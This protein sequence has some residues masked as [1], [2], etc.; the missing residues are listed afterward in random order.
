MASSIRDMISRRDASP[1]YI[2]PRGH[3]D[4]I[5]GSPGSAPCRRCRRLASMTHTAEYKHY[6]KNK[7]DLAAGE[8]RLWP[9]LRAW[10]VEI[11]GKNVSIS[12]PEAS[13]KRLSPAVRRWSSRRQDIEEISR[14]RAEIVFAGGAMAMMSPPEEWPSAAAN[15]SA[16]WQRHAL[17]SPIGATRFSS[18]LCWLSRLF[19]SRCFS[20]LRRPSYFV[21]KHY[22]QYRGPSAFTAR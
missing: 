15:G 10:V 19:I 2:G 14:G 22:Q 17:Y 16:R 18:R 4:D 5:A 7:L 8:N 20:S 6:H 21:G 3:I 9:S 12:S 13:L 1:A 11:R